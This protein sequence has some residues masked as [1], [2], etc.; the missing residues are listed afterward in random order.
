[1]KRTGQPNCRHAPLPDLRPWRVLKES[2][3]Y[4]AGPWLR[5][6]RQRVR[7]P[8][9][10]VIDDYHQVQF[11]DYVTVIART[12]GGRFIMLRKYNHGFRKTC[13]I[14]PGGMRQPDETPRRAAARELIEETGFAARRLTRLGRFR[15]HSNYGCG[16][17]HFFLAE[18]CRPARPPEGEEL[19]AVRVCTLSETE[20]F[21][22]MR[23]GR[24]PSLSCMAALL[25]AL[26]RLGLTERF[27]RCR[28]RAAK[29]TR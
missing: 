18:G 24:N 5:I 26:E 15:P 1:M 16:Q 11:P 9:G 12:A 7:L 17:V 20:T 3:V 27:R 14:F 21:R 22:Y 13:L 8:D 19:E 25:L 28:P 23:S 29:R 2:E 10:R 6:V 4:A